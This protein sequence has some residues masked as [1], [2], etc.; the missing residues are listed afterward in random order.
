M[1]EKQTRTVRLSM[2][3]PMD[4]PAWWTDDDIEFFLNE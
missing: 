3:L 2:D 4:F 1:D